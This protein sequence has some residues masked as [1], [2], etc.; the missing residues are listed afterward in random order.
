M[1]A[2]GL[3]YRRKVPVVAAAA[4]VDSEN[5]NTSNKESTAVAVV[6]PAV[7]ATAKHEKLKKQQQRRQQVRSNQDTNEEV[8]K[9]QRVESKAQ[10][11]V[12]DNQREDPAGDDEP[13]RPHASKEDVVVAVSSSSSQ[14]DT[15]SPV[16]DGLSSHTRKKKHKPGVSNQETAVI[17]AKKTLEK[18]RKEAVRPRSKESITVTK[19]PQLPIAL[20]VVMTTAGEPATDS[21]EK[22][23]AVVP[24]VADTSSSVVVSPKAKRQKKKKHKRTVPNDRGEE[25]SEGDKPS[26]MSSVVPPVQS[27]ESGAVVQIAPVKK[28]PKQ[29]AEQ[30]RPQKEAKAP[31]LRRRKQLNNKKDKNP[32]L[33]KQLLWKVKA[34]AKP[35]EPAAAATADVVAEQT[36]AAAVQEEEEEEIAYAAKERHSLKLH[37]NSLT[38]AM[39]CPVE[40]SSQ[41]TQSGS[42]DESAFIQYN[43][44][45][46]EES[47]ETS[48]GIVGSELELL[49][50]SFPTPLSLEIVESVKARVDSKVQVHEILIEDF[51]FNPAELFIAKGDLVVWRVSEQTLGMVEHSLDAALFDTTGALTRKTSTPLLGPGNGFAW[52]F[53][54]AERVDIQC[55]VYKSQCVV[56]ISASETVAKKQNGLATTAKVVASN[57]QRRK[58]KAAAKALKRAAKVAPKPLVDIGDD[59]ETR[60]DNSDPVA[61]FHPAKDLTRVPEMDAGVCRAVLTQLEE[62]KAAAEASFIVVGDIPCPLVG[63]AEDDSAEATGRDDVG[64]GDENDGAVSDAEND[65][66]G[67][68]QQRIIAMLQ[69]SEESQARQRSSFLVKSSGFDA[70]SAYDF[71][72]RR[73]AQ[74]QSAAESVM[75]ARCPERHANNGLGLA[76]L[77]HVLM[78]QSVKRE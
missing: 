41:E 73:F 16:K 27:A 76:D 59:V 36:M 17:S 78:D 19:E 38:K 32:S 15:S 72:K 39:S 26:D 77:L 49:E 22:Q 34:I 35:T 6:A 18:P 57:S 33:M 13:A 62:V 56:H 2:M 11:K 67:D 21:S 69:K 54:V 53:D 24:A 37:A 5:S 68:F 52:R 74:V 25:V 29:S 65:E 7:V 20:S 14:S 70:G 64:G 44:L 63:E 55:S 8:I 47:H 40:S 75:Y 43:F 46:S 42:E 10:S 50:G 12:H 60:S 61:V 66:V 31:E 3:R 23:E 1:L 4:A 51:V 48:S 45:S 28:E 58:K 9:E 30:A 71:F